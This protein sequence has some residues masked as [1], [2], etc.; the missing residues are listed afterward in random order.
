MKEKHEA[1]VPIVVGELK[2]AIE[3]GVPDEQLR[4]RFERLILGEFHQELEPQLEL[5]PTQN[6]MLE[7][8]FPRF[9]GSLWVE[10]KVLSDYFSLG[11][12]LA[13]WTARLKP[14]EKHARSRP[15]LN[16]EYILYLLLGKEER[17][18]VIGDLIE[19]YG[20]VLRR[21]SKRHADI[22]F[23][24]QVAGSLLPLLWRAL[25]RIGALVWLGRILQR[26]IS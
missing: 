21:F 25:L 22:W 24:K 18:E 2:R 12:R 20:H 14:A 17:D 6:R 4:A 5:T 9:R 19:S 10:E 23:Y 11:V 16:A 15:P 13:Q 3:E 8:T 7:S 26:L 1:D